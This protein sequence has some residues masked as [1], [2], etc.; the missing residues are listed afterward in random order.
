MTCRNPMAKAFICFT[1]INF[2]LVAPLKNANLWGRSVNERESHHHGKSWSSRQH[3]C[4]QDP[5]FQN[6]L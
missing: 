6:Q 5:G 1:L 4:Q 3:H 2:P